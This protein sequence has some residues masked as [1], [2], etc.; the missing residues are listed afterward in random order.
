MQF[1]FS[2]LSDFLKNCSIQCKLKSSVAQKPISLYT[3]LCTTYY[4]IVKDSMVLIHLAK[5]SVL[6]KSCVFFENIAIPKLIFEEIKKGI[7]LGFEDAVLINNLIKDKKIDVLEVN[8]KSLIRKANE[9]NIKRGEAEA[10]ALYWENNAKLL[11][12]DDDNVR[13]KRD[14]LDIKIIGT[15]AIILK[16]YKEDIINKNKIKR[17]INILKEIGWFHNAVLDKIQMEVENE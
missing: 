12:T 1:L 5:L 9:F 4:M 10:V 11:A 7:E 6:E 8:D 14:I 16:L 13:K 3:S 17:C 2:L 15:L